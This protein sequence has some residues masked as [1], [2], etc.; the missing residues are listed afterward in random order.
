MIKPLIK[1][2][3]RSIYEAHRY[4]KDEI[5]LGADE[6]D[7]EYFKSILMGVIATPLVIVYS[8][9]MYGMLQAVTGLR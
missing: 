4:I 7:A 5:L 8:W 1:R 3:W 2:A 6:S 9:L